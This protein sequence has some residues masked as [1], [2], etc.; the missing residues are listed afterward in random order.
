MQIDDKIWGCKRG[1]DGRVQFG[2]KVV[3]SESC[4]DHE[5]GS[6][7]DEG[8]YRY[9]C[10]E[11]NVKEFVGCIGAGQFVPNGEI[12]KISDFFIEC[13]K[14]ENGTITLLVAPDTECK[15]G[16]GHKVEEGDEWVDGSLMFTC[17][18]GGK[19]KFMGCYTSSGDFVPNGKTQSVNGFDFECKQHVNGTI[20]MQRLGRSIGVKCKDDGGFERDQ[21][22]EWEEGL[23][24]FRCGK[25]GITEF[26]GC[27]T[28]S[29]VLIPNG[30][31]KLV[32]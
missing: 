17:G 3:N 16:R 26:M 9:K 32:S 21:G 7:W 29:K 4:G 27:V 13:K 15:D 28:P 5:Y 24:R 18:K 6:E 20:E 11:G 22:S 14:H 1:T 10:G 2:P 31:V 30:D 25:K 23:L 12:K 19:K 8:A